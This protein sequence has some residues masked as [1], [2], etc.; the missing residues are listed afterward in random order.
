MLGQI[1]P[2]ADERWRIRFEQ[3]RAD[4]FANLRCYWVLKEIIAPILIRLLLALCVPHVF[5]RWIFPTFG[6]SL[7]VNSAVN[8]FAWL[9]CLGIALIWYGVKRLRQWL[10]DLHNSIRDDRYLVGRRLHN[11]GERKK[12]GVPATPKVESAPV[13]ARYSGT[14]PEELPRPGLPADQDFSSSMSTPTS[15]G[16]SSSSSGGVVEDKSKYTQGES[17]EVLLR[18]AIQEGERIGIAGASL[19]FRHSTA[20]SSSETEQ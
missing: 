6:Y 12:V 2:L 20:S 17:R 7:I 16:S 13:T 19:R 1:T 5:A 3:V 15:A 8:R 11:F 10:L 4:G 9:G 14:A 18:A